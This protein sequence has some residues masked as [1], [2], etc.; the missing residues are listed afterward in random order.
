MKEAA[1]ELAREEEDQAGGDEEEEEEVAAA[2][3]FRS[4]KKNRETEEEVE[5]YDP[6]ADEAADVEDHK[7]TY[8]ESEWRKVMAAETVTQSSFIKFCDANSPSVWPCLPLNLNLWKPQQ[9]CGF[10]VA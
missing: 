1:E 5:A 4:R 10:K 9:L 2:S 8:G 3:A 7:A 6:Q